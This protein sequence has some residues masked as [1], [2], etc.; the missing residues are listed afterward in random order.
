MHDL[1]ELV[2]GEWAAT[3]E[4]PADRG[5]DGAFY[6]LRDKSEADVRAILEDGAGLGGDLFQSFMDV[7]RVNA[8]GVEALNPDLAKIEVASVEEFARNMG[9]LERVG[10]GGPVTYWVEKD[11]QGE[12]SVPY[13][14]Q[15][16]LGLPDEAYYRDE[17]HADT[18]AAYKEHVARMLRFLEPKYLLGLTPEIAA[19][20]IVNLETHL[21]LIHISEPTRRS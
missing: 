7:D 9:E 2:N 16:G 14:V 15:S 21:S 11:S 20:R 3:H 5:I 4:I 18:L 1:F 12:A 10:I 8:A 6:V 19:E 17:D 13:V